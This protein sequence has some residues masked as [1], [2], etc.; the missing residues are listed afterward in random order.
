MKYTHFQTTFREINYFLPLYWKIK[1]DSSYA[2]EEDHAW[3]KLIWRLSYI[4]QQILLVTKEYFFTTEVF[5][6]FHYN[7]SK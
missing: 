2:K 1:T 4:K 3:L 6:I 5:F 7:R